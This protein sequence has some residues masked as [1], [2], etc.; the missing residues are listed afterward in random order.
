[1]SETEASA[2]VIAGLDRLADSDLRAVMKKASDILAGRE[3]ERKAEALREI[4][5]IAR[6][7]GL[8]VDVKDGAKARRGR[9]P[10]AKEG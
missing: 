5:K 2:G 7:H 4:Q 8:N 9:P 10:K 6:A 3:K 1:M